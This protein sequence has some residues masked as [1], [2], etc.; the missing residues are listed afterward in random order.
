MANQ[1]ILIGVT[2]GIF[3]AG[4]VVVGVSRNIDIM[5]NMSIQNQQTM[6]QTLMFH[7]PMSSIN[8]IKSE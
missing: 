4:C 6:I 1:S 7:Q 8:K 5:E 2:T 3:F